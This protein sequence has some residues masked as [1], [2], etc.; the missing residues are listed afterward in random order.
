MNRKTK[1]INQSC[2]KFWIVEIE[3]LRQLEKFHL[4]SF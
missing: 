4:F 3:E 2:H 1:H